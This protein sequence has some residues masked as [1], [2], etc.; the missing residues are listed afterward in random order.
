MGQNCIWEAVSASPR[1]QGSTENLGHTHNT[2]DLTNSVQMEQLRYNS[3]SFYRFE[4]SQEKVE[5][6][7]GRHINDFLVI[8][9]KPN[10]ERLL[11]QAQGKLNRQDIVRLY[12]TD[13]EG[14][15]FSD[16]SS[17]VGEGNELQN[18]PFLIHE[19]TADL[20]MENAKTSLT[21]ESISQKPQNDDDQLTCTKR[22]TNLQGSCRQSNVSHLSS[23]RYPTTAWIP[24]HDQ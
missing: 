11:A 15:L 22:Y 12:E 23:T 20:E 14:R 4:P 5:Q 9:P 21:P 7:A 1:F 17:K 2:N 18:K 19:I 3:R 6:K 24:F 16:D 10:V 13:D 8:G